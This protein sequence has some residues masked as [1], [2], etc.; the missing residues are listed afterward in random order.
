MKICIVR[1]DK[2]G[3][4]ILTLPIVQGLKEANKDCQIDVICSTSNYKVCNKFKSINNN[5]LLQNKCLNILKIILNLRNQNYD[6]IFTFSPGILSILISIFSK[7]KIKSLLIL[8]SR[9]KNKY[10]GK[11]TERILGK[12]FFDQCLT[13]DRKLRYS[14]NNQIH[15]TKVMMELVTKN[16]LD[17]N[18]N[19]EVKN[20]FE[21]GKINF[22]SRKLCMI[23]LSSKWIN[24]YFSEDN[25]INL[26]ENLKGLN[27]NV[28]MTTDNTSKDVFYKIYEKYNIITNDNLKNLNN[29]NTV[30]I[31]DNLNFDNWTSIINSSSY[32]ITPECGCT[33]I[34]SLSE[35][36]LCVIYDSDNV[37]EMIAKEYAPWKKEYTRIF[38]NNQNLEQEL[39]SFI[40]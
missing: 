34:A 11:L 33:H 4:M 20:I 17:L 13:V 40:N 39:I 6:Y 24:K 18:I 8:K 27:I 9:Y 25:F 1:T 29:I 15:Q 31:L 22:N 35:A 30:L 2:M 5:F 23:H 14:Q 12:V 32:I 10:K 36:K 3:D 21:L 19:A 37:P 7:S 28:V 26:L 38:S 16:G